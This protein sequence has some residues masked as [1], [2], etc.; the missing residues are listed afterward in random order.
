MATASI[1]ALAPREYARTDTSS[2]RQGGLLS[3]ARR[4]NSAAFLALVAPAEKSVYRNALRL[5]GN[6]TDAE[7]VR[8]ETMLRAYTRLGQFSGD[9]IAETEAFAAWLSRIATNES[10]DTIRRRHAGKVISLDDPIPGGD[11]PHFY[12]HDSTVADDPE[13]HYARM[14]MR[15]ILADVIEQLDP[16]FRRVCLLRDVAQLT[17]DETAERLGISSAAVRIRLF[18]ARLKLRERLQQI[19][20][21]PINETSC[22]QRASPPKTS[23]VARIKPGLQ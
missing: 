1:P 5:T 22:C 7:D 9:G 15:R 3:E 13:Q 16:G 11:G 20:R 18:R 12:R 6:R 8:Q 23:I 10:I 17:T 14:E 2:R 19:L 21:Q 4:G